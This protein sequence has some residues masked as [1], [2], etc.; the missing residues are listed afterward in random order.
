MNSRALKRFWRMYEGLNP[1]IRR[2]AREAYALFAKDP[3]HRHLHFKELRYRPGY[4]SV[5]IT[6]SYRAVCKRDGDTAYWLWIGSH[7]AFD[8]DFS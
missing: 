8:R 5:R 7:A 2:E 6:Y 4:W 1:D 3:L